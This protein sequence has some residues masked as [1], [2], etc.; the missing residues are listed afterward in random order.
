MD[1]INANPKGNWY[2]LTRKN[3]DEQVDH[4]AEFSSTTTK[5]GNKKCEY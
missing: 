3:I 2:R 1:K 4:Q 5:K